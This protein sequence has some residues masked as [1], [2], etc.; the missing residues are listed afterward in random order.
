MRHRSGLRLVAA[1]EFAKGL[2]VLLAG[3]GLLSL[4]HRKVDVKDVADNLLYFLRVDPHHHLSHVFIVAVSRLEDANLMAVALIAALYCVLRFVESYGL[5]NGRAW[6]E[7][8]A[9]LSGIVYLPL[10]VYELT[11]KSTELRWALLVLNG[12]I[13]AYVAYVRGKA[14]S[15]SLPVGK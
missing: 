9:M 4:V 1:F 2:L 10:E 8:L 12:A 3:L 13:V 14:K 6:A 7:W 15:E 11:R 5:W